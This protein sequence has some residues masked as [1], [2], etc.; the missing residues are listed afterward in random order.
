[1]PDASRQLRALVIPPE[2]GEKLTAFGDTVLVKLTTEQT[3]GALPVMLSE[4]PPG[5]GP[6][7]HRHG[8]EHE[9]F[10]VLEGRMSFFADGV[11][12]EDGPGT[13]TFL[14]RGQA[15]TFKNVGDAPSKM[16]IIT[17]PSGFE[18]FFA[19]CATIFNASTPP[20]M[21]KIFQAAALHQIEFLPE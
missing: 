14:P 8:H 12:T 6:P 9:V 11:W 10:Y 7:L 20:D 16:L 13:L 19:A 2:A 21:A 3:G 18:Q 15:H 5:G 17:L 4:A 1:M